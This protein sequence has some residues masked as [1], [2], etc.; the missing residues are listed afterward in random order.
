[1]DD[2]C[3]NQ[4]PGTRAAPENQ[5][6]NLLGWKV[7]TKFASTPMGFPLQLAGEKSHPDTISTARSSRSGLPAGITEA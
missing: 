4:D 1:M 5:G 3:V 2:R 7:T 6:S